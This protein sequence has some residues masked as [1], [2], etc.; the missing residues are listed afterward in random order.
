MESGTSRGELKTGR[1]NWGMESLHVISSYFLLVQRE[2]S[3]SIL[4]QGFTYWIQW[5]GLLENLRQIL[6][7]NL[8]AGDSN[9]FPMLKT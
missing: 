7:R 8:N 5:Q 2:K 3:N 9:S 6:S 4:I 1:G